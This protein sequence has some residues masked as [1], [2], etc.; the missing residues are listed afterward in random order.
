MMRL[1][2]RVV[3]LEAVACKQGGDIIAT[4]NA[5]RDRVAKDLPYPKRK[6][7][8]IKEDMPEKVKRLYRGNNRIVDM[9]NK[10]ELIDD[11]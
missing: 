6:Y 5:G 4:L 7:M 10:E 3:V 2:R 8:E 9:M 11:R 1:G